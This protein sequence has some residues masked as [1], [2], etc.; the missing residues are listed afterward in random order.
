MFS[1]VSHQAYE[2]AIDPTKP[3]ERAFFRAA[4]TAVATEA[5]PIITL[6]VPL[7][8][9]L[10]ISTFVGLTDT[11][12]LGP[13]GAVPLAAV[14]LTTSVLILLF[15]SLYGFMGPIGYLIGT[16]YGAGDT[17]KISQVVKHGAAIG[18]GTGIF[19]FVLMALAL[20]ALP[21]LGQPREVL[22][23][24]TPYWLFIS[25]LLIPFCVGL[26]YKQ[27]YDSMNKAWTGV[28]LTLVAVLINIPLTYILV[29]GQFGLPAMGLT[30]AGAAGFISTTIGTGV[31]IAHFYL[32]PAHAPY[33]VKMDWSK[34][35]FFDHVREGL[36]MGIQYLFEG[37]AVA[38]AGMLIGLLGAT[39]LA[40]NQIVFSVAGLLYMVP[41]GMSAA[42]GIRV[43]QAA[44]G[45][46]RKRARSIGFTGMGLVSLWTVAFT[47]VLMTSGAW[48]ASQFVTEA[49]VIAIA[50]LMFVSM[51]A[52]QIFDG[53]Q[54]VGV[55]ALRGIFDNR[56]PT[57]VSLVAYWL[58]SLPLS[59]L[60]GFVLGW[61]APGVWAGFGVGLIV[62]S[63]LLVR[64]L[65]R[66][67]D[68]PQN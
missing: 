16:A 5:R 48:V 56:Y 55:G 54:S 59:F 30:G 21:Y 22:E 38:V 1:Q 27:F 25:A 64:R 3:N 61:G 19:G 13:L 24:I 4:L 67:A 10:L 9:G 34:T 44:G 58:I 39:A 37:G 51:G 28:A 45:G 29:T 36:P 53:I 26:A 15:S 11:F 57:V 41:L 66:Q 23:I 32:T 50:G 8:S 42:V 18:L 43:A 12:F 6:A 33:H 31:M 49:A 2:Q 14:S 17:Q 7:T 62:A 68:V 47:I 20:L 35:A 63:I 65:N 60:F 52:M 40:A 46:E